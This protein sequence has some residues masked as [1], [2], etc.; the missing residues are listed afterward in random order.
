MITI[1]VIVEYICSFRD[2]WASISF[3]YKSA[4]LRK[5]VCPETKERDCTTEKR[6]LC[7]QFISPLMKRF[8]TL[9][10]GTRATNSYGCLSAQGQRAIH[11]TPASKQ[12]LQK[13]QC[14]QQDQL[15]S[16]GN[17]HLYED[18]STSGPQRGIRAGG[19]KTTWRSVWRGAAY[20]ALP[21]EEAF[22]WCAQNSTKTHCLWKRQFK[23]KTCLK[24][25]K[26]RSKKNARVWSI[27]A[28][29]CFVFI[30]FFPKYNSQSIFETDFVVPVGGKKPVPELQQILTG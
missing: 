27:M 17:T 30:E 14:C 18:K 7:G 29:F 8:P 2:F 19:E 3:L 24:I 12:W 22:A 28:R 20:S 6:K 16:Y 4:S 11:F 1:K 25:K 23:I 5:P 9:G 13:S 10:K 15:L 21:Q 26:A